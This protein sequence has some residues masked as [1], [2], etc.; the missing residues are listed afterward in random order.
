MIE[1]VKEYLLDHPFYI[2][3]L[4]VNLGLVVWIVVKVFRENY[5][6]DNDEQDDDDDP[7]LPDGPDLDLPPGVSLPLEPELVDD[8]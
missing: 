4:M 1:A 8:L 5:D 3:F 2:P 6:D 7:W